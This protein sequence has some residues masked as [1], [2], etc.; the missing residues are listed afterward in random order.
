MVEGIAAIIPA[1]NEEKNIEEVIRRTRPFV[2]KIIVIDDG[3]T[4]RTAELAKAAG[5]VVLQH[6]ANKGKGE[7]LRT[8]FDYLRKQPG[9]HLVVIID[10]DLQFAPEEA[11]A[12]LEP[13]KRGRADFVM[14]ARDWS[15]VP[16][17]HRLGNW[18]WRTSFN[19]FFGTSLKDTNCGLI[20]LTADAATKLN[21]QGGYIIE[22][23]MLADAVRRHL[24]IVSVPVEVG[25]KHVSEV[26]RGIR[27]VIGVLIF[28]TREGI[29]WRLRR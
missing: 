20:A 25:Y 21:F 3:S 5:A 23:S 28:I 6:H 27:M 7:A 9:I 15:K 24:R 16:F 2:D 26:K 17:R 8:G 18:V 29:R 4:D 1:L 10:A 13:L 12:V 22:N 11:P 14:G 19:L